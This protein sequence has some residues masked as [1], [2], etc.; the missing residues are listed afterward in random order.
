MDSMFLWELC[1]F[2]FLCMPQWEMWLDFILTSMIWEKVI[3][4]TPHPH[5]HLR[6]KP[7]LIVQS[8]G[9]VFYEFVLFL[10]S[11]RRMPLD[12]REKDHW[13]LVSG[14]FLVEESMLP[15]VTGEFLQVLLGFKSLF[16]PWSQVSPISA[17]MTG[18]AEIRQLSCL[19]QVHWWFF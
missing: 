4:S 3:L 12:L 5:P 8:P 13:R 15:P 2:Y 18:L 16:L 14:G 10:W 11:R 19:N 17:W 1:F 9:P 6:K 7:L